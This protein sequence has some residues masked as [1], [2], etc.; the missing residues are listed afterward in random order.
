MSGTEV[1]GMKFT[2]NLSRAKKNIKN[3]KKE[4]KQRSTLR[5]I[6]TGSRNH[7]KP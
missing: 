6:K 3:N 5:E 1:H 7:T 2:K 4:T